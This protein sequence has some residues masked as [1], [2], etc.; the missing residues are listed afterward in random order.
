VSLCFG[1]LKELRTS[2]VQQVSLRTA[3]GCKLQSFVW[4]RRWVCF[5]TSAFQK[6][7]Y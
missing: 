5:Q 4:K 6:R 3:S 1:G 7:F 2:E